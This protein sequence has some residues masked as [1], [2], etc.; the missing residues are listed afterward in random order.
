LKEE[1]RR[2][3]LSALLSMCY[4]FV[5]G[6]VD[7]VKPHRFS[8]ERGYK[9][10]KRFSFI[11]LVGALGFGCVWPNLVYAD[12]VDDLLQV[13]RTSQSRKVRV[14]ALLGLTKFDDPRVTLALRKVLRSRKEHSL[15]RGFA[16]L[17]LG[18][19]KDVR[20]LPALRKAAHVRS[21]SL[22]RQV[23]KAMRMLC[24]RR[25]KRRS[26]YLN[27]EKLKH[28]GPLSQFALELFVG[29]LI[30]HYQGK[31]G[32]VLSWPRCRRPKRWHLR[33]RR[34]KGFFVNINTKIKDLG[35]VT[36]CDIGIIM[37]RYPNNSIKG[38]YSADAK[39]SASPSHHV[40]KLLVN[41][42]FQAHVQTIDQFIAS[43]R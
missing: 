24:P 41:A 11:T 19:L 25:V 4:A 17:G 13:L 5:C 14:T 10:L 9:S 36:K 35:G 37:A 39:G 33:R 40:I 29:K 20:A 43:R 31:K 28:S 6:E 2:N 34:T 21:R 3:R 15:V 32:V 1:R 18:R 16:A 8:F 30:R 12:R 7:R 23:R 26:V 22:R 38:F 42:L 27:F